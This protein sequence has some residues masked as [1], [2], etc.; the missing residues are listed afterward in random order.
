MRFSWALLALPLFALDPSTL[1]PLGYLSDFANVVDPESR[2]KLERYCAQVK[3][4]TGAEIA[5]VTLPSLDGEPIEDFTN[6]LFRQW[7]VGAKA[8][9]E[10]IM[11]LLSIGDR[12]SRLEVGYGLEPYI[13]DGYSGTLLRSMRPALAESHYGDAFLL[14][15][16]T[17]GDRIRQTKGG[18]VQD[19]PHPAPPQTFRQR[20]HPLWWL[21]G[22]WPFWL[23]LIVLYFLFRNRGGPG[24][25][26]FFFPGGGGGGFGGYGSSSDS[27]GFGGFGGGDS[28]G[29][30]GSSDW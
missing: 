14:A 5:F 9:N 25:M 29:G 26:P 7:G 27:G 23:L 3:D 16:Q 18:A 1:K 13:P 2:A 19:K 30:G 15:A 20:H 8:T 17:I 28:G 6:K 11:L 12:K 22:F 21:T 24:G 4:S 10:G